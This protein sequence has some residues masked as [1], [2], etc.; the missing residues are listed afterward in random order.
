MAAQFCHLES[1]NVPTARPVRP[2][3]NRDRN[4]PT[5]QSTHTPRGCELDDAMLPPDFFAQLPY[6]Q[7]LR[8]R[9]LLVGDRVG[10]RNNGSR[11]RAGSDDSNECIRGVRSTALEV[12]RPHHTSTL[13]P[14]QGRPVRTSRTDLQETTPPSPS[15]ASLSAGTG[16]SD[17]VRRFA[18]TSALTACS[19]FMAR[20]V[21]F[22]HHH[23]RKYRCLLRTHSSHL[24]GC[25]VLRGPGLA[26]APVRL[27]PDGTMVG[28]N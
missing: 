27:V 16:N 10:G 7:Y 9:P 17:H 4:R 19:C 22:P 23:H 1:Q 12:C 20:T 6:F 28:R 26:W 14:K 8:G 11:W 24:W 3:E 15:R 2:R 21:T 18:P 5:P 25:L 13:G